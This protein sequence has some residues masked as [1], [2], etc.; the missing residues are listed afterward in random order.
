MNKDR[1]FAK[2]Y[3]KALLNIYNNDIE[4]MYISIYFTIWIFFMFYFLINIDITLFL[5]GS[6]SP[7][8]V[9]SPN[10]QPTPLFWLFIQSWCFSINSAKERKRQISLWTSFNKLK[11]SVLR[12]CLVKS[13]AWLTKFSIDR[14]S[15]NDLKNTGNSWWIINNNHIHDNRID[16]HRLTDIKM[17]IP[18]SVPQHL[19]EQTSKLIQVL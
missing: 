12:I 16:R 10:L 7:P 18:K 17:G 11:E 14:L 5:S 9:N 3:W 19:K 1:Y 8:W 15:I 4:M 6:H 13:L 2:R